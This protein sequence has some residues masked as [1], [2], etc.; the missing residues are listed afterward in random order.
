MIKQSLPS[1][2][3]GNVSARLGLD[4]DI[5]AFRNYIYD[6]RRFRAHSGAFA[7]TPEAIAARITKEYHR[8]EKGLAL[9]APR[10][11][12]GQD[13]ITYLLSAVPKLEADHGPCLATRGSRGSLQRYVEFH[14]RIGAKVRADLLAFVATNTADDAAA[15]GYPGGT[16]ELSRADIAAATDFDYARFVQSRYSVRQFTGEPVTPEAIA[17]A[18]ELALKTPRVCNRESRRVYVAYDATTR[19]KVLAH[20]NGNRGFGDL[21]GAVLVVTSDMREFLDFGERNQCWV[22]GGL[23]AM[24][25]AYALHAQNIGACM[26]NWSALY[27]RDQTMRRELGIPDNEAVITFMAAGHLPEHLVLAQSPRPEV[28]TVLKTLNL[29]TDTVPVADTSGPIVATPAE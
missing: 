26:L 17:E 1:R 3:I 8:I 22:D 11:N 4:K 27:W 5:S 29:S 19:A 7:S 20:Q 15:P 23:F 24:S 16:M 18:V 14:D 9:P 25:L 2:L 10:P 13:T 28:S 12:F 6:F 21:A